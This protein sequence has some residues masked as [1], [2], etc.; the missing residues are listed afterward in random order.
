MSDEPEFPA[1]ACARVWSKRYSFQ[2]ARSTRDGGGFEASVPWWEMNAMRC[3]RLLVLVFL[4]VLTLAA[5]VLAQSL[6]QSFVAP[7][8][9]AKP[10]TWW[11]WMNGNI[12]SEGIT[13]DLEAM[14]RVGIG[15]AQIFDVTDGIIPGKVDYMS[16]EWRGMIKHAVREANRLGLELCIHNCAGWS[17]SG[18]P[19][20]TPAL[21]MQMVVVSEQRVSGPA[22]FDAILPQPEKRANYYED[23]A[24]LAFPTPPA[25]QRDLRAAAPKVTSTVA[26][27]NAAR[28]VDG[29]PETAVNIPLAGSRPQYVQFEFET[30]FTAQGVTLLPGSGRPNA[31]AAVETSEDG[32]NW[33]TIVSFGMPERDILRAPTS[34]AFPS[35][36][37][38]RWFRLAL[39]RA[40]SRSAGVS[41]AEVTLEPGFRLNNWAAKAGYVRGNDPGPDL[42]TAP[43]EAC[44]PRAGIV[45]ITDR[46]DANG[47]LQWEVPA[48]QWTILRFGH[49][50]TGK[51][52][53]PASTS[54]VGLECD[55]CSREAADAHWAGMLDKVL[56]DIGP[57]A[58]KTLNNVLIDS[59]EV[60][61]QNW[62]PKM[63][64]E[65]RARRG[66]DLL[67]Y[68]PTMTGRVVGS[69]EETERFLWDLRKTL[70][71][72]Y[73]DNYYGYFAQLAH[74]HGLKLSVEPYGNGN[75]DDMAA[76]GVAD[77]P[78]TEF[79]AGTGGSPSGGKLASSIAHTNGLPYV[80]AESFTADDVN[81][82]WQNHP[83]KLKALGDLMYCNGVNR[84]I[85]HRYA[86][87]PWLNLV[88]GMTMGPH[89]F[90]FERTNTWFEE[91]V[92]WLRYL[93]RCQYMLQTGLFRADVCYLQTEGEP[94]SAPGR[95]SLRPSLPAGYDYDAINPQTL[96]K[97]ASVKDGR[98][99]LP[100]GMSYAVLAVPFAT[101]ISPEL[102]TKVAELV[103]AGATVVGPKPQ[104]APGLSN[105]PQADQQVQALAAQLWG[106]CD[107]NTITENVV[108]NGKV[109]W[110]QA[111]A[112]VL[113]AKGLGVDFEALPST[114]A[115]N[116]RWIH[117]G[118]E[119]AEWYFV[120]SQGQRAQTVECAFRVTGRVPELWHPD[121]GERVT[122][123]LWRVENGR[124]ILPLNF[125]P[126]GSVFVVFRRSAGEVDPIVALSK[127]GQPAWGSPA[128]SGMKL[129]ITRATYGVLEQE[130]PDVVDVTGLLATQVRDNALTVQATNAL[131]GDPAPNVVKQMRVTYTYGDKQYSKT[132]NENET[133]HIPD[134][135]VA[136]TPGT[137]QIVRALYGILP[138]TDAP[139]STQTVDVT[140]QLNAMI[141]NGT[142]SVVANNNIAGDPAHL[143]V[144]KL[145]VEY[146]LDGKPYTRTVPENAT[147][148]LPDGTETAV[149]YAAPLQ[150]DL[151][152]GPDG[153]PRVT[154][155]EP[156]T[157]EART[158]GGRTLRARVAAVE[159][160]QT[161]TGSWQVHF[162][163]GWGAPEST[164]FDELIN[165]PQ[166]TD[167]GIKYF[168]GTARYVKQLDVPAQWLG[169]GR[170]VVLDL[171]VV[172]ELA[173]VWLNGQDLGTLWKPPF[174]LDITRWARPGANDLQVAVTNLWPNRLIGDEELPDDA[175]WNG[176]AIKAWP[177]WLLEGKPRP[178]TGRY[179]FTTWKHWVK[180]SPLLDS[181]LLG[182]VVLRSGVVAELTPEP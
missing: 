11:H 113:A 59:Y 71:D 177:T 133:L 75:F 43:P 26:A 168:S 174:R 139:P 17:S 50:S 70:A 108:G 135:E 3:I 158:A 144:K 162:P 143:I 10:H 7:P 14:A 96:L 171:G 107:G 90:H 169:A 167:P 44:I 42:R 98:I 62:T 40:G 138:D 48:G 159:P 106:A 136:A 129:V 13:A 163:A 115:P 120:S 95:D 33:R 2:G 52:N 180:G 41:L 16:D 88:P 99:V 164:T 154:A 132:V 160:A 20:I 125:D 149:A 170:V 79:W 176:R 49:T 65:F 29:D 15:G 148:V 104:R 130:L 64:E 68:L 109:I 137:L 122:A 152:V 153:T 89:G 57:L 85:F 21:S 91:S 37:T 178:A 31:R 112:D 51:T 23:I 28:I 101:V 87:Q 166:S 100:D 127:D 117:R 92:A 114:P 93:A 67:P 1:T 131:A 61:C 60:G 34:V 111:L 146:T 55:K 4:S 140:A 77:I 118:N 6:E 54:G 165:W 173:H 103:R 66:Y 25:E 72:L 47:R 157:Y 145:R 19:W 172:R 97:R 181:G 175:E 69:V 116:L 147:L 56:A 84:F 105:Q 53:H 78:M 24:V 123:P 151:S 94:S 121:T 73:T 156:G 74:N 39:T 27:F 134:P 80:G 35:S 141:Q 155:W 8:V 128:P 179:T 63:R 12:T 46:M 161:V 76:G 9:S 83:Y 110:G 86:H 58:G 124:T 81:G 82:K 102:L 150:A 5:P 30:P 18:G 38:S 142:L 22:Q 45:D 32:E 126:S 36:V 119:Q 182:P